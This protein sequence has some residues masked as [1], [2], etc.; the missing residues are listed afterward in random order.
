MVSV[1]KHIQVLIGFVRIVYNFI[2]FLK[3]AD[4]RLYFDVSVKIIGR[5]VKAG[6]QDHD[7]KENKTF[8][9]WHYWTWNNVATQTEC[10]YGLVALRFRLKTEKFVKI[11]LTIIL[12]LICVSKSLWWSNKR[13]P[14]KHYTIYVFICETTQNTK[15][16]VKNCNI[17]TCCV[18][19]PLGRKNS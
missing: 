16:L 13:Y 3:E 10:D 8:P 11:I 7:M 12:K 9:L 17:K 1:S 6:K 15:G 5:F 14:K 2:C 18:S 19:I 4:W